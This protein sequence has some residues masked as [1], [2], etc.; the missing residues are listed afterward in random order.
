M[1]TPPLT[2]MPMAA[3]LRSGPRSSAASQAPL[4]PGT[5]AVVTPR[6]RQVR[7]QRL[8][9]PA[10]V[11]DDQHVVGQP[12]DR[13]ADQLAGAVEGDLPAAVHVDHG[14]AGNGRPLVRVGAGARG[15]DRRVLEEEDGAGPPATTA[16]C[17]SR[18][19]SHAATYSTASVPNPAVRNS[20]CSPGKPNA[21]PTVPRGR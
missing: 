2:R 17:T 16:A 4:R 12:H 6:S 3:I 14:S 10:H 9:D 8:L 1:V 7:D 18:C 11:V 13:V 20:I 21:R 15:V 19:S 5:R